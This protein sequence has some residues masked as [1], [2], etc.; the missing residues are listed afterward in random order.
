[1]RNFRPFLALALSLAGIASTPSAHAF[2]GEDFLT[3]TIANWHH[4]DISKRGGIAASFSTG[5]AES[6]CWHADYVDSYGYNPLWWAKSGDMTRLK[7]ALIAKPELAK[8]HFDDL[9]T[10]QSNN[11]PPPRQNPGVGGRNPSRPPRNPV[12]IQMRR[13][14][15]GTLAGLIYAAEQPGKDKSGKAVIGDVAMAH[16]ILG[17]SLHALQDF[18]SHSNWIDEPARRTATYFDMATTQWPQMGSFTLYTG[19]YET[20]DHQGIKNHGKY[21]IMG[22]ILNLPGVKTVMEAGCHPISPI[23]SDDV[24]LDFKAAKAG[25]TIRGAAVNNVK[26][27]KGVIYMAPAGINLDSTWM[28]EIGAKERGIV[29]GNFSAQNAFH[30]AEHNAIRASEQW[31][32]RVGAA[33]NEM[34]KGAFWARIQLEDSVKGYNTP[35][36]DA[37]SQWEDFD[38]LGYQFVSA[39]TYPPKAGDKAEEFFL[40]V[41]IKT[42][43]AEYSGTDANIYAVVEGANIHNFVNGKDT[44][45]RS[46]HLDKMPTKGEGNLKKII[47]YNDFEAGDEDVYLIGPLN[48][49]PDTIRLDNDS[50]SGWDVVETMAKAIWESIENG[51]KAIVDGVV[52][53]FKSLF[54]SHA[55]FVAQNKKV[56]KISELP[57][58]VGASATF[59]VPLNGKKEGNYT[60]EVTVRKT[61]DIPGQRGGDAEY[62]VRLTKLKCLAEATW[63]R[64][65]NSDE[66]FLAVLLN[67]LVSKAQKKIIGPYEDVDADEEVKINYEFAPVRIPKQVGMLTL[68]V[69]QLESDD[70]SAADRQK[71]LDKFDVNFDKETEKKR[72]DF[73]DT[74]G[75]AIAADWK[76]D[77]MEVWAFSKG[78][79]VRSGRV[80]TF[81]NIGWIEGDA[82]R[83]FTLS[84]NLPESGISAEELEDM[85]KITTTTP[86]AKVPYQGPLVAL[87]TLGLGSLLGMGILRGRRRG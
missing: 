20:P 63:D 1:M 36:A 44:H 67:P 50:A 11:I 57:Q 87:G 40:R 79:M 5:A 85:S 22:S 6:I 37:I 84:A 21:S 73:L 35:S 42:S 29:T 9:Y 53:F 45:K 80:G 10:M 16:H 52:E 19:N 71:I 31:L 12:E 65:S 78:D 34:G 68:P 26:I 39:G 56:W 54:G 24:C 46:F 14:L 2:G 38:K 7:A 18:Y 60:L 55:D 51:L 62:V 17:V 74:L 77:R 32:R 15:S 30:N 83:K 70:E 64:G 61:A 82:N 33:M 23:A 13:Y 76:V 4:A 48:A 59:S 8:V 25:K 75:R 43:S 72:N 47:S 81:T 3:S 49:L 86:V 28:A 69:M 58:T 27:P 66:P 41:K